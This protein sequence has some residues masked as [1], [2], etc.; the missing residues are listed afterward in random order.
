MRL[1]LLSN[2]RNPGGTFL[3]HAA[4]VLRD[5]LGGTVA[6]AVFVPFAVLRMPHD[7]ITAAVREHFAGFGV[8]LGSVHDAADPVGAIAG[9][10]A[11]VVSGGNTFAL[12]AA[13]Y[14]RGLLD[15][16]RRRVRAGAPYI[17]WSAGANLA[18]PTIRT[19]NDMPIVQPPSFAALGLVP[20]QINPHFTDALIPNHGGETRS[21]RLEEFLVANPEATVV[22]LREGTMLRVEGDTVMLVGDKPARVFRSG[23]EPEEN[24]PGPLIV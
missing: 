7:E 22:G 4:E 19:T 17:G 21:E 1:L 6:R 23:R 16:M 10:E 13:L 2:S 5:F 8:A 14:D 18:C 20:F 12:L 3:G 9:A 24:E 11:I 15:A